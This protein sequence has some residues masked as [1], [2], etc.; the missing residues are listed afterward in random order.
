MKIFILA[1]GK[2]ERWGGEVKQ[3]ALIRGKPLLGR[4]ISMLKTKGL[5]FTILTHRKEI[6]K[7]Y[8]HHKCWVPTDRDKLLD[9]VLSSTSLWGNEEEICFLMG[10]VVYTKKAL[11][12]IL[13]STDKSFQF[14]GSLDEHFAFRFNSFWYDRVITACQ[15]ITRSTRQGTTWELYRSLAGIP[16]D[17]DWTD[18]WFRTLILDKTDDIDYPADYKS[19][20]TSHYFEDK[21]FDL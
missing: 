9:T 11:D 5:V 8:R 14:Y 15:K 19:K 13:Q 16:L 20:I 18:R 10:D 4:T 21:E 12:K 6:I 17:K 1:A 3:M 2:A 7:K